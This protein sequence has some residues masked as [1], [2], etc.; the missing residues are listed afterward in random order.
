MTS[1]V[2]QSFVIGWYYCQQCASHLWSVDI[3]V[4]NVPGFCDRLILLSTMCQ[5]FV[6][7]WYYCQQCARLLWLVDINDC[8][9]CLS[10]LKILWWWFQ[11]F[12]A[13]ELDFSRKMSPSLC[14]KWQPVTVM[15]WR[16]NVL[17]YKWIKTYCLRCDLLSFLVTPRIDTPHTHSYTHF[18]LIGLISGLLEFGLGPWK[19]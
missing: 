1:T 4:N 12:L 3:T 15:P 10:S 19:E 2:C 9:F 18:C 6:I 8:C 11:E 7:G 14:C 5:A 13:S 16:R 17:Q